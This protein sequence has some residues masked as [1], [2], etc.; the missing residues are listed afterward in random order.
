MTQPS[1]WQA[2]AYNPA[3]ESSNQIHSDAMA[4]AY[5]YKGGLVPGVVISGYLM[6]PAVLAWGKDW[7]DRG[8]ARVVVSKP[9]YD[10]FSFEVQVKDATDEHYLADLV[11]QEGTVCATADV[12]L[13]PQPTPLPVMRGDE[14]LIKGEEIPVAEPEQ[15]QQLK[16]GGMRALGITWHE[17]HSMSTYLQDTTQMPALHRLQVFSSCAVW[18]P[19]HR[20][21]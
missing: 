3:T 7:L 16:A 18:Q 10:G 1:N 6:N 9:L 17:R 15:M 4:K 21:M 14:L 12:Q 2:V 20:R 11:D 13:N 5:G 8:E 19:T